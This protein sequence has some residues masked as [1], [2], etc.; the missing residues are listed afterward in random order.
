MYDEDYEDA[1]FTMAFAQVGPTTVPIFNVRFREQLSKYSV[2][3]LITAG[4]ALHA[5][6]E[7][8][9]DAYYAPALSEPVLTLLRRIVDSTGESTRVVYRR[10]WWELSSFGVLK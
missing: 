4:H 6:C 1:L 8:R 10:T 9:A 3:Q 5:L 2:R 7:M